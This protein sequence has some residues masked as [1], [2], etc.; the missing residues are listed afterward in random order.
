MKTG[1]KRDWR[2]CT[3]VVRS[4]FAG[5]RDKQSD[6]QH[7]WVIETDDNVPAQS[8]VDYVFEYLWG[9]G[10]LPDYDTWKRE[11]SDIG[12]HFTDP[13]YFQEGYYKIEKKPDCYVVT[14]TMPVLD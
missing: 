5:Q 13:M 8:V 12:S 9:Y 14:I 7:R 6:Y 11:V 3:F 10:R 1:I 4:L 2:G